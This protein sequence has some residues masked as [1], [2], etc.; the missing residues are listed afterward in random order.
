MCGVGSNWDTNL[1]VFDDRFTKTLSPWMIFGYFRQREA[2]ILALATSV[3]DFCFL[4]L[5]FS[6]V[7]LLR[8]LCPVATSEHHITRCQSSGRVWSR[9]VVMEKLINDFLDWASFFK[10]D[11]DCLF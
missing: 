11:L 4:D 2:L 9:T 6:W 5:V 8:K 7:G 1:F 3:T 10:S